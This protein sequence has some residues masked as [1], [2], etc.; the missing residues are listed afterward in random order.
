[1]N[2]GEY[3]QVFNLNV[4]F[5]IS[6]ATSLQLAITRPDNTTITAVPTVGLVDLVTTD[7]GTYLAKKYCKYTFVAGDLNQ[8]GEYTA[9]LTYTDAS[10]RL[11][12]DPTSFT[13]SP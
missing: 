2:V 5:D 11:I 6:A 10:K 4:N 12:S 9:R 8:A 13:V 1:M 3:G 7:D